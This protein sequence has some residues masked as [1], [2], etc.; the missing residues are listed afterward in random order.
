MNHLFTRYPIVKDESKVLRSKR[1][2]GKLILVMFQIHLF[3]E[4]NFNINVCQKKDSCASDWSL[5]EEK[6]F[7]CTFS[8]T[9][10]FSGCI[11]RVISGK[12]KSGIPNQS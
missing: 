4:T 5:L 6:W 10:S 11:I 9:E 1:E 8:D 3:P 7:N 2:T 12:L